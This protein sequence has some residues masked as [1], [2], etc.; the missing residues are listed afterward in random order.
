MVKKLK[1][2]TPE[3]AEI[4]S[5]LRDIFNRPWGGILRPNDATL[6][7]RGG[8][9]GIWIYDE[10][11]RDTMVFA[12]LQK[13]KM[14][15]VSRDWQVDP[16]SEDA[17]DVR[18]ADMVRSQLS[19]FNFDDACYQLLDSI[20]K[21]YAVSEIMWD[22]S[23]GETVVKELIP[24]DQRR[25]VFDEAAR[26]RL[27]T[28]GDPLKGE[29]LPERKFI[30]HSVGAKDGNPYG[31]GI[32]T[33]L[34]WPVWFKREGMEFWLTFAEKFGSPT[35]M[36]KFPPGTSQEAQQELLDVLARVA[37]DASVTLPE[38]VE[39]AL[40]EAARSGS[41]ANTYETLLRYCDEMI[42]QAALGESGSSRES[43]GALAAASLIRNEV[44]LELSRGDG[45]LLSATLN[46]TLVQWIVDFNLP[47]ARLPKV[48]REVKAEEDLN[49][50]SERDA[51]I[52]AMGFMPTLEYVTN[53]YGDGWEEAS[54]PL[55]PSGRGAGGE[56]KSAPSFAAPNAAL[57]DPHQA[58][59]DEMIDALPPIALNAQAQQMLEPVVDAIMASERYEEVLRLLDEAVP[60]LKTD[61]LE[62][63]LGR[64]M[65]VAE[66]YGRL[67]S[68]AET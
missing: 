12:V 46:K 21:G 14:A 49:K 66:T 61:A 9:S 62:T 1:T 23:G 26:P 38:G 25:F 32:G 58:V 63:A 11:E 19:A 6:A 51:R 15:V 4:A 50:R 16:A 37:Q 47:G 56:G 34:Y 52:F 67:S 28:L 45:D 8:Q 29:E 68:N 59:I 65:F 36:G 3:K 41:G 64:A 20:L 39:V 60:L 48:W 10:L 30:V 2:P 17:L 57:D 53:T 5:K 55:P 31:L 42:Q 7:T 22:N 44:R 40:L 54:S 24:R 13:R 27:L 18:A 33:R 35:V 43:G